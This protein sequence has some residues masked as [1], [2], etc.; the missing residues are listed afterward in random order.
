MSARTCDSTCLG[1][2]D[3]SG[4]GVSSREERR[5]QEA[6]LSDIILTGGVESLCLGLSGLQDL[7]PTPDTQ[8]PLL[9]PPPPDSWP[10]PE[11]PGR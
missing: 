10:P 7:H 5:D 11:R 1:P 6:G 8:T 9:P 3:P 4:F 2:S